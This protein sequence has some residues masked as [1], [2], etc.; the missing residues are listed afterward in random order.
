MMSMI[1]KKELKMIKVISGKKLKQN[2]I[3]S[4]TDL[5]SYRNHG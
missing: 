2:F 4:V 3:D 5:I 1:R